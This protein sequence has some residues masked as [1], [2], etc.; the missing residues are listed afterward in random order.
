MIAHCRGDCS[1]GLS[2]VAKQLAY[3]VSVV[4]SYIHGEERVNVSEVDRPGLKIP[5]NRP[6]IFS[7]PWEH[8]AN[9]QCNF[10]LL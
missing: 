6:T 4:A 1:V 5:C 8:G 7:L 10:C 9:N 3:N 2:S